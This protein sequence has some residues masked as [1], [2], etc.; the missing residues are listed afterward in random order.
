MFLQ[1]GCALASH[2]TALHLT[3]LSAPLTKDL[4]VIGPA[5]ASL[6]ISSSTTDADLFLVLRLFTPDLKEVTYAGTN[7]PHTPMSHG[8]LRA[9]MRKLD[10]K[11]SLPY[12]PDHALDE[13][14][15]LSPGQP[16]DVQIEIVPTCF[17][18]PAG[19]RI[20]LS[21]RGK[22]YEYPGDLSGVNATIGQPFTGVGP[23]RHTDSA[24]RPAAIFENR[25][26]L[27]IDPVHP[28][29]LLLPV[30]PAQAPI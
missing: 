12:R 24:D 28:P 15:P 2:S 6:R 10:L 1:I 21:L 11:R 22:D 4:H 7:D 29:C 25:V 8:W 16:Y 30:V 9:S 19:Y 27:H 14:Q 20:G 17:V 3:F 23:F 13:A 18:A 5:A 26:T